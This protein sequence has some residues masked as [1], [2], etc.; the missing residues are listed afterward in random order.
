MR[1]VEWV[2]NPAELCFNGI[3]EGEHLM[4]A[5]PAGGGKDFMIAHAKTSI[6]ILSNLF[7]SYDSYIEQIG[8]NYK[9]LM[10]SEKAANVTP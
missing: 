1:K 10:E 3:V 9:M 8:E 4:K 7:T 6:I 5:I 2:V